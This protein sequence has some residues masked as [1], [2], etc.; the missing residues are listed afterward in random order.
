[1]Y[2]GALTVRT[3]YA[4]ALNPNATTTFRHQNGGYFPLVRLEAQCRR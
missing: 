2:L 4:R 1:M 3:V